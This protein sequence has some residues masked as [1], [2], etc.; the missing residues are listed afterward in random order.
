MNSDLSV[1]EIIDKH[2]ISRR[3][4]Y[5]IKNGTKNISMRND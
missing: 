2:N 1:Q 4:Y 3:S 5:A